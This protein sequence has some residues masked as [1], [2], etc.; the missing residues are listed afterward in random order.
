MAFSI[1]TRLTFWYTTLLFVSLAAFGAVFSYSLLKIFIYRMDAQI[2]SIADMMVH[3]AVSP[4]GQMFIPREF[5]IMLER[6]FGVRTTGSYIQVLDPHGK[7]V[8]KSSNLENF[9]ITVFPATYRA[10]VDGATTYE[11]IQ[12][13]GRYPM[14]VVTKPLVVDGR[15]IGIVQVGSSLEGMDEIFHS[16][17]YIL[18][19]AMLA[20]VVV[21][22]AVG[23]FLAKKALKPVA[24]ITETARK[25]EAENLDE[26][27]RA[28]VPQDEIG[29][30]A[31]TM[32]EMIERL[33]KSFRQIRQFTG[34]ASHE[35]KTPLTIM[36]GEIEMALRSKDDVKYMRE[37]LSSTLEEIDRMNYIVRSLLDLAKMDVEKGALA[38]APVRL[39]KVLSDRGEHFRRL[40]FDSGIQLDILDNEPV[41]VLGD[42]VRLSQLLYN[43]IDNA[44]KY[45]QRGGRVELRLTRDGQRAVFCVKD[46]GVGI[47]K[48]DLP[49]V[50][51]RFYRVDKARTREVGGAGLGLAICKEIA[52]AHGGTLE[53]DSAPGAG[54]VFTASLPAA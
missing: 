21:A 4:S 41:T 52:E 6:H 2:G 12:N 37:V 33:E 45:T 47:S 29:Q 30:L 10:A 19:S 23:W 27:I 28:D 50:F 7:L 13:I 11:V 3:T 40:A 32:N 53:A 54:S 20:A 35:L 1:R 48:E 5:D 46:T 8:A 49:F 38:K 25:I 34:D 36:K 24:Q 39:D 44:I 43:L 26:R 14:R 18:V 17:A 22:A 16:L 51:D 31:A 42:Q 9:T 15:L